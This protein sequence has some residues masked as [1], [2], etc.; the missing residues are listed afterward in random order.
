M[1]T[2]DTR[3]H[4]TVPF[5][6]YS[7]SLS[8]LLAIMM[9]RCLA[10]V[11]T[12]VAVP[13]L[14]ISHTREIYRRSFGNSPLWQAP[15]KKAPAS[16][17]GASTP[18]SSSKKKVAAA[19]ATPAATAT[20]TAPPTPSTAPKGSTLDVSLVAGDPTKTSPPTKFKVDYAA[21]NRSG[22]AVCGFNILQGSLR[23]A[24]VVP[25][26]H[27]DFYHPVWHHP[28][29]FSDYL[30][31]KH[32]GCVKDFSM[33][34]GL[35]A[36]KSE[37]MTTARRVLGL[38]ATL[39]SV[40]IGIQRDSTYLWEAKQVLSDLTAKQ[41]GDLC[42][43]N[44][45]IR[46]DAFCTPGKQGPSRPSLLAAAEDALAFGV[47]PACQYCKS[48]MRFADTKYCCTGYIDELTKCR[49]E[50]NTAVV[51][52]PIKIPNDIKKAYPKLAAY[53]ATVR[54]RTL[55]GSA[56]EGIVEANPQNP[57]VD[58]P[59]KRK[60]APV[61]AT[62]A[63]QDPDGP[64]PSTALRNMRFVVMLTSS[65]ETREVSAL[66]ANH[67]GQV[68]A[69][70]PKDFASTEELKGRDLIVATAADSDTDTSK[71]MVVDV[72]FI[73][74]SIAQGYRLPIAEMDEQGLIISGRPVLPEHLQR[75]ADERKK[76]V[77]QIEKDAASGGSAAAK[78]TVTLS[79]GGVPLDP[80]YE[81]KDPTAEVVRETTSGKQVIY[82]TT[83]SRT[84]LGGGKNSFYILQLIRDY[85]SGGGETFY[86]YRRW[87]KV[88][89]PLR[90]G[91]LCQSFHEKAAKAEFA[92]IFLERSGNT[93]TDYCNDAFVQKPGFYHV[94][95]V[96]YDVKIDNSDVKKKKKPA[97]SVKFS[98]PTEQLLN[99]LFDQKRIK[100]TLLE[101]EI[102]LKK[103]PLGK[104]SAATIAK[105]YK[106]LKDLQPI[107][108]NSK[109]YKGGE[110]NS[111]ILRHSN[112]FFTYI[113]QSI[114]GKA[115]DF[116][117]DTL[118]KLKAKSQLLDDLSQ[119]E[120]T[121][122]MLEDQS[123]DMT[124]NYRKLRTEL[125][126]IPQGASE[127]DMIKKYIENTNSGS[128]RFGDV[129]LVSLWDA[130][131]E[132][133]LDRYKPWMSNKNRK[134]LWHGSRLTNWV[135][136]LSQGLRIAP[137]EA[138]STGYMFGK[139]VYFADMFSKS[140]QYCHAYRDH[141]V[142]AICEVALGDPIER[143][144]S[145][146][147]TSLPK[148][149][150]STYAKG[151]RMPDPSGDVTL[152]DGVV[153]PQGRETSSSVRST[154]L[155]FNEFIVYDV[156]QIRLRYLALLKF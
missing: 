83:M 31:R 78:R 155:R 62:E 40:E 4:F 92:K 29:C 26:P 3:F 121:A 76:K 58:N 132:G 103:L 56:P 71:A 61:V 42:V 16:K 50:V 153:I 89:D 17:T 72:Q 104:L 67:G 124:S 126:D 21:S 66:I 15:K 114:E 81:A 51:R 91:K 111:L 48:P 129:K 93:W 54:T 118:E 22:C 154:S 85:P 102:D 87:G 39:T 122:R 9:R 90:N 99:L 20:A 115:E 108:E 79:K 151:E 55:M 137:P 146:F 110:L 143:T 140:A 128:H 14:A 145:D 117:I 125:K 119:L 11:A 74:K 109:K 30:L 18:K 127:W 156:S 27:G 116:A 77:E 123:D 141:A 45:I 63:V 13:Q 64:D 98:K 53:A 7:F 95:D 37:D 47:L 97:D 94:L 43:H 73:Q 135:G 131:R 136:I 24:C 105:G 65:K 44:A 86:V 142:M 34:S 1:L 152:P 57:K 5:V 36:V 28:T 59:K 52:K 101:L 49:N 88:G 106:A 12:V 100:S 2:F 148:G 25:S 130:A 112:R 32:S 144:S 41:L 70:P 19:S 113:P 10:S 38:P 8:S 68:F 149:K 107:L 84:D 150:H 96:S 133:E 75:L 134:L 46:A 6:V 23:Y 35:S 80:E 82:S 139:G 120:L 138:P 33:V 147:I 60:S 69:H